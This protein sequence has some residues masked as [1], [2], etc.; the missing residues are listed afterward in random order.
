MTAP[1]Q[2]ALST[3]GN[4][5]KPERA[6]LPYPD[7]GVAGIGPGQRQQG[8]DPR[9][10]PEIR[11]SGRG[12]LKSPDLINRGEMP[13]DLRRELRIIGVLTHP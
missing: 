1:W 10:E 11:V 5:Q 13:Q 7:P 2:P 3:V 9:V 6:V 4:D 8:Q 12:T